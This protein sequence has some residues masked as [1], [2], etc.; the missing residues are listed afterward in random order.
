M[1]SIAA[2]APVCLIAM[3]LIATCF[4]TTLHA[5][6]APQ[7]FTVSHHLAPAARVAQQEAGP[8]PTQLVNGCPGTS[9]AAAPIT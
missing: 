8:E 9:S 2:P 6:L 7:D 4:A 5:Q 3:C 1:R